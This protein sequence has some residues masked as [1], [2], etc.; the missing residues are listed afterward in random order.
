MGVL[1]AIVFVGII[2]VG[3]SNRE[4]NAKC[5]QEVQDGIAESVKECRNYYIKEKR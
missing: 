3:D 2:L 4:L 1:T 5:E